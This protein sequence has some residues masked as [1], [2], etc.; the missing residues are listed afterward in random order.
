[1]GAVM[2]DA[3]ARG[4]PVDN[5]WVVP[6]PYWVDTRL[7]PIWAGAPGRD[8]AMARENLPNTLD[9]LGPKIFMIARDDV[10]TI[11]LLQALFPLG[12]LQLF[13]A[14]IDPHDF[15]IYRVP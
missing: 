9:A 13:E 8:V 2:K 5:V 12:E 1:M 10:E 14:A 7:P 3:I 15:W 4:T 11:A 6:F